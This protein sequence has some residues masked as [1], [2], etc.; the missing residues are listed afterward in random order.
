MASPLISPFLLPFLSGLPISPPLVPIGRYGI[1][2]YYTAITFMTVGLGDYSVGWTGPTALVEVFS[3]VGVSSLGIALFLELSAILTKS[4]DGS[5][6]D[7]PPGEAK[8]HAFAKKAWARANSKILSQTMTIS[9]IRARKE[10]RANGWAAANKSAKEDVAISASAVFDQ[11]DD[12]ARAARTSAAR[13]ATPSTETRSPSTSATRSSTPQSGETGTMP[14]P[15][16]E[17]DERAATR[18]Q[19]VA[20]R[21]EA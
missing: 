4:I 10:T 2:L 20:R 15:A 13:A 12:T 16:G 18:I 6:D 21:N 19:A 14:Q 5:E 9:A 11:I 8:P 1:S 3:L 17:V 7:D